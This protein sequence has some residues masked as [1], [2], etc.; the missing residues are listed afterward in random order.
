MKLVTAIIGFTGTLVSAII[1]IICY[2]VF[3]PLFNVVLPSMLPAEYS[4]YYT[5]ALE[6][7]FNFIWG[8]AWIWVIFWI[9]LSAIIIWFGQMFLKEQLR[10]EVYR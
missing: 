6:A 10:Q 1:T 4:E 5:P 7:N 9:L 8:S 3:S 2:Y